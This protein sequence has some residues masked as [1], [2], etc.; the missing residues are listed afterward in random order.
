MAV[1]FPR[2]SNRIPLFLI[3]GIVLGTP[4]IVGG[5][6]YYFSPLYTDVGYAPKQ[7][8]PFSH[9]FHAGELGLD[10]KYCHYTVDKSAKAAIPPTS[11]CMGCHSNVAKKSTKLALLRESYKTGKPIPWVRVHMLPDYAFFNHQVHISAGVGCSSCHGRVDRMTRVHQSKSLS[12]YWCLDCHRA[13]NKH[14]RPKSQVTNMNWDKDP[15]KKTYV[16]WKDPERKIRKD[17]LNYRTAIEAHKTI[18]RFNAKHVVVNPPE[19]CS[20]CHR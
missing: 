17:I 2:W 8:I 12:M 19:H 7:P 10:C 13:P 3:A 6:W 4:G 20:G 11:V 9:K 18:R 15:A 16:P 5:A 14:L 1:I